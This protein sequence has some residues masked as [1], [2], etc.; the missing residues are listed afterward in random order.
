MIKEVRARVWIEK[1]SCRIQC[2]EIPSIKSA[3][4]TK[5]DAVQDIKNQLFTLKEKQGIGFELILIE[6][7]KIEI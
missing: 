7:E 6:S 5:F 4:P 2:L 3:K 1:D